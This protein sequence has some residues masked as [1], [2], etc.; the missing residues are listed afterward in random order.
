MRV[1]GRRAS[2]ARRDE[3]LEV[4]IDPLRLEAYNVTAD[5]LIRVVTNNNPFCRRGR[6][7]DGTGG[8]FRF[9]IPSSFEEPATSTTCR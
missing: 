2:P 8:L 1:P 4:V 9:K 6:S 5:E 7:G 3:M